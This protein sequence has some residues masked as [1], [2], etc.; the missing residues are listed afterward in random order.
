MLESTTGDRSAIARS[1][2]PSISRTWPRAVS[3]VGRPG[4]SRSALSRLSSAGWVRPALALTTAAAARMS[5]RVSGQTRSASWKS[6]RVGRYHRPEQHERS[7]SRPAR[8]CGVRSSRASCLSRLPIAPALDDWPPACRL[9][10]PSR[11]SG[12][13][14]ALSAVGWTAAEQADS[15]S[16]AIRAANTDRIRTSPST[17]PLGRR[18]RTLSWP[19]LD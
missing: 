18:A 15:T 3:R 13:R 6:R 19:D 8:R 11:S 17:E 10:C 14:P 1:L 7:I 12:S 9:G 2:S 5:K 16:A 4:R